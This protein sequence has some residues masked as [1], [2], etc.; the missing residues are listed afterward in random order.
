VPAD[1]VTPALDEAGISATLVKGVEDTERGQILAPTLQIK[2][3]QDVPTTNGAMPTVVTFDFGRALAQATLDGVAV[4]VPPDDIPE[5]T[6]EEFPPALEEDGF[7][8][9]PVATDVATDLDTPSGGSK[10]TP[11]SS[12]GTASNVGT[13]ARIADWSIAPGYSAMGIGALLLL[14]AWVGLERIA[15]RLRWR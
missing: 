6:F 7:V 9:D 3:A 13:A 15:V 8:D 5:D 14:A 10:T 11:R 12:T 1:P 2:I 4:S